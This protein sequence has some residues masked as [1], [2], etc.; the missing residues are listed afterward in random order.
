MRLDV[1]GDLREWP[2]SNRH[3]DC[4]HMSCCG[5]FPEVHIKLSNFSLHGFRKRAVLALRELKSEGERKLDV[6]ENW[7][8][9]I[10]EHYSQILEKARRIQIPLVYSRKYNLKSNEQD[11]NLMS[12]RIYL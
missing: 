10:L 4:L 5:D 3:E 11:W 1:S 6:L 9:V 7:K 8:W 12:K 2:H